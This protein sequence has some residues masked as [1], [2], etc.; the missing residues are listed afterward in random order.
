[1]DSDN[2]KEVVG[3]YISYIPSSGSYNR[4]K[5]WIL[6]RKYEVAE[7]TMVRWVMGIANPHPRMKEGVISFI[8]HQEALAGH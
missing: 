1:M 5:A 8:R 6:A 3:K 4:G 7:S 2:F